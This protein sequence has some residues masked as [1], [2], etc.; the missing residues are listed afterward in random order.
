MQFTWEMEPGSVARLDILADPVDVAS[1]RARAVE[2]VRREVVVPGF[3]RGFAPPGKIAEAAP[4]RVR[5]VALAF[6]LPELFQKVV[7]LAGLRPLLGTAPE[8]E[9]DVDWPAIGEGGSVPKGGEF[10]EFK[11]DEQTAWAGGVPMIVKLTVRVEVAPDV[12]PPDYR[13][14]RLPR[15]PGESDDAWRA[16]VLQGLLAQMPTDPPRSAVKAEKERLRYDL[17]D[18]IRALGLTPR[19]YQAKQGLTSDQMEAEL[20]AGARDAVKVRLLLREVAEREAVVLTGPELEAWKARLARERGTTPE[21]MEAWL[22]GH[23]ELREPMVRG[24]LNEK[25]AGMLL[26]WAAQDDGGETSPPG[27][28]DPGDA[29]VR[30]VRIET[31]LGVAKPGTRWGDGL[32]WCHWGD[33]KL[34]VKAWLLEPPCGAKAAL[35]LVVHRETGLHAFRTCEAHRGA[36]MGL[37][38][39]LGVARDDVWPVERDLDQFAWPNES[40]A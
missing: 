19:A 13:A 14:F 1:A 35:V 40:P 34:G 33:P 27:R 5:E 8:F 38:A 31:Q 12:E 4:G 29:E 10:D 6:L 21:A 30:V 16:R 22:A 39:G 17:H 36:F 18:R 11:V 9:V 15:A 25:A 20:E 23:Q 32:D 26:A 24:L 3:R 37:F 2:R 7:A 28:P